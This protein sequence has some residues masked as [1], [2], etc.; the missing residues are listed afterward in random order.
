MYC[1]NKLFISSLSVPSRID[2]EKVLI[3]LT[4][5]VLKILS[6]KEENNVVVVD[7]ISILHFKFS[8]FCFARQMFT[9]H[10]KT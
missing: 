2:D 1:N 5:F 4:F 3:N 6:S 8:K 9:C 7:Y 10:N